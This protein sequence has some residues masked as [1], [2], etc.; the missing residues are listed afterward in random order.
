MKL[1]DANVLLYA[2]DAD[3][4]HHDASRRWLDEAL[5]GTDT[6]LLPWVCALAFVRLTTSPR[7]YERPLSVDDAIEIVD[8]WLKHPAA[9]SPE[10][11]AGHLD[12]L[13]E[14][15]R[16][17]RTGGDLVTD[18]HLAAMAAQ[19]RS[20]VVTFDSDFARFPRINWTRPE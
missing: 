8:A 15:L 11:S 1:V 6:V 3:S 10:P 12:R 14:C 5:S 7:I 19:H 17:T 9:I 4:H 20:M 16:A 13:R 2:V 18:A